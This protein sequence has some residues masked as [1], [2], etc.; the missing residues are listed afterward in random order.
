MVDLWESQLIAAAWL[1]QDGP[2]G[3]PRGFGTHEFDLGYV[4][5]RTPPP[6]RSGDVGSGRVVVDR[7]NGELTHW[8]LVPVE[9]VVEQY[10][11]FRE[12][13]PA[14]PLT[15]DPVVQA[16][17]DRVRAPF[18]ENVTRLRLGDGRLRTGRSMKGD[19]V[20]NLH[21]L[22]RGILDRLP[23][24]SRTRGNDRCSEVAVLSDVMHAEDAR[25]AAAGEPALSVDEARGRLLRGADLVT[26]RVREPG[27]PQ[28]GRTAPPCASC[29]AL[30]VRLGL[31]PRPFAIDPGSAAHGFET[32]TDVE[33]AMS[34]SLYPLGVEGRG[35]SVLALTDLG[36]VMAIDPIGE[37]HLGDTF[38]EALHT[39][40]TGRLPRP[41]RPADGRGPSW[42]PS[43][44]E[45]P[46]LVGLG[47]QKRPL[48]AVFF[49]PRTPFNLHYVWLPDMLGRLGTD[50]VANPVSSRLWQVGD[51]GG[52]HC[53]AYVLDLDH[54]TALVLV[55][56][57]Y[58]FFDQRD[59]AARD[60]VR[61]DG[62]PLVCAFRDAC[63]AL[64][65]DLEVAFLYADLT[66]DLFQFIAER[67]LDVG[68]LDGDALLRGGY[69]MLYLTDLIDYDVARTLEIWPREEVP[70][71]GGRL[72]LGDRWPD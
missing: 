42:T 51:W 29:R 69:G 55:F 11:A 62:M 4:Y 65:P 71:E 54:Y 47:P 3:V 45:P 27:D 5:W 8:P 12:R 21:P 17:R 40:V 31:A 56:G 1:A 44:E 38:D 6:G 43:P 49:M 41:V 67:Q 34:V 25:R 20:P 61:G 28:D 22:V 52:M 32:L 59:E 46:G 57:L 33:R 30:L 10:R 48:G 37:W 66:L 72:I 53:E 15:W 39:L 16:R 36:K 9:A 64:T 2:A 63:A 70:I 18:P 35:E 14:A 26:Y 19:G 24:E 60:G 23:V 58:D 68:T 50:P 13:T 7:L